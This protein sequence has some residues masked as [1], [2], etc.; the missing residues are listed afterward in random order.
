MH[1]KSGQM[2][3]IVVRIETTIPKI[4]HGLLNFKTFK[5][6]AWVQFETS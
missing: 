3:N 6:V 5:M 4:N 2:G 1:D